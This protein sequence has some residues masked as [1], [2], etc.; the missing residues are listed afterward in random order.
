MNR[1]EILDEIAVLKERL[2]KLEK[3]YDSLT[4]P[5]KR[6]RAERFDA[7][8]YIGS[9]GKIYR[10]SEAGFESDNLHYELGN[11][12]QTEEQAE[13][14]IERLKVIAELKEWSTSISEFN[15]ESP[16]ENKYFIKIK[17]TEEGTHLTIGFYYAHQNTDLVFASKEQAKNA[18][19]SVGEERILKYYFRRGEK[20]ADSD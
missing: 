6:W 7:Y 8:Y 16:F 5:N 10:R 17:D 19:E 20:N 18:I 12:F 1:Q 13:F 3:M 9:D 4:P 15:W 14:E 11:Y 2:N